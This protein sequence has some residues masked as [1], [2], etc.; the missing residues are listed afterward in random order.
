MVM[1]KKS[2]VVIKKLLS[3]VRKMMIIVHKYIE[4]KVGRVNVVRI[5]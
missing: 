5:G 4:Q 3:A 1:P 2:S